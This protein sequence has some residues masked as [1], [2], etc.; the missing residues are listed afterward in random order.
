MKNKIK[1]DSYATATVLGQKGQV[2]AIL[3]SLAWWF[4][5]INFVSYKYLYIP[6]M[7]RLQ[8]RIPALMN[9]IPKSERQYYLLP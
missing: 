8:S 4:W 9:T 3:Y 5:G 7:N 6:T 2:S 1:V